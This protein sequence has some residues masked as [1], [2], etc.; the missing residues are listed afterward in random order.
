MNS[1]SE[2]VFS[3]SGILLRVCSLLLIVGQLY[4]VIEAFRHRLGFSMRFSAVIQLFLG[5]VWF[6]ILLDGSY[7]ADWVERKRVYPI[8]V[9]LLYAS[10]WIAVAVIDL[11][12]TAA[13]AL[14]VCW[15]MRCRR[16]HLS[17]GA[18]KETVDMLPVGICFSEENGT[19]ALKN[20]LADELC[21][22]L[23]G[24]SLGDA[25]AFWDHIEQEGERQDQA[26]IVPLPSGKVFLCQSGAIDVDGTSYI[27][28][29]AGDITEQYRII[30]ELREKN[31]K[32]LDIQLRMKAFGAMA[33]RLAMTEELLRARV[34]VHDEMGHLLLSGK[35][36]LDCPDTVDREQLLRMERYTH[37]MLMHEGS[38]PDDA[39]PDSIQNAI[40]VARS[41]N[42]DVRICGELPQGGAARE[43]LGRAIRECAANTVKHASGDRL[44]VTVTQ[45]GDRVKAVLRGNGSPPSSPVIESGGLSNLRRSTEA[46]GGEMTVTLEPQV[47]VALTVPDTVSQSDE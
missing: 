46:A 32:L 14:S 44:D 18:I 5:L 34:S 28:T 29:V 43:L 23:T 45:D 47:T 25:A 8:L 7:S 27:Q 26:T 41:M 35:H 20:L 11:I 31:H 13:W 33:S 1:F 12:L 40:T 17:R 10:P 38:E 2:I 9:E 22:E 39:K 3:Y 21:V 36:C 37:L 42:T 4:L 30:T 19:V 15:L 6:C 24:K 16:Q